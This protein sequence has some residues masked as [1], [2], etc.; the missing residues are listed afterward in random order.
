MREFINPGDLFD[1]LK[2]AWGPE[3]SGSWSVENP[4]KGHCSATSLVIHDAFGGSILKTHTPGG[5]H[6]YNMVDGVRWDMTVSRFDRPIPFADLPS[7]REEALADATPARY[8]ALKARM[9][10]R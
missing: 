9:A 4:A 10:L 8:E 6:F 5:T 3:S 1:R 2:A 7:S